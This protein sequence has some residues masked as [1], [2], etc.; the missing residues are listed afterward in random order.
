MS[1]RSERAAAEPTYDR[2]DPRN[3]DYG[4]PYAGPWAGTQ[5]ALQRLIHFVLTREEKW[6]P[7]AE[8][9]PPAPPRLFP[10]P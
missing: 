4:K 6:K 10:K 3:P 1:K 2:C 9:I 5:E 8:R 7:E